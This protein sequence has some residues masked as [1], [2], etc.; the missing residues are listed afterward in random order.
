MPDIY[1][2]S[3]LWELH[4]V[5]PDNRRAVDFAARH[6]ALGELSH[7]KASDFI[8]GD[9]R[10][11]LWL[12]QRALQRRA[13]LPKVFGPHGT[14]R[15]LETRG[16]LAEHIVAF[17]RGERVLTIVPRLLA[18]AQDGWLDTRVSLPV[19]VWRND[20]TGQRWSRRE[21]ACSELFREFPV[22]L[23]ASED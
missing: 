13:S 5:D 22:A 3:E 6:R 7:G 19:G 23:L 21:L 16:A 15:G 12:M 1:Q 10:A 4:L 17:A 11:K 18:R 9:E 2:G 8:A 14:Y 20:L